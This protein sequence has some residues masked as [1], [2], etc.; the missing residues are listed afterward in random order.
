MLY[1]AKFAVCSEKGQTECN[2]HVEFL[3]ITP[4]DKGGKEAEGV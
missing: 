1:K 2:Q 3:N 4:G